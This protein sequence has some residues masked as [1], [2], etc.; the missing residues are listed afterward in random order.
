MLS[1]SGD[2]SIMGGGSILWQGDDSIAR[3]AVSEKCEIALKDC[4]AGKCPRNREKGISRNCPTL[5]VFTQPGKPARFQLLSS[6][7]YR[8]TETA[9]EHAA[10][11]SG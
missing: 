6:N 3:F 11:N 9:R 5:L 10:S 2:L 1:A 4:A 8:D 7:A